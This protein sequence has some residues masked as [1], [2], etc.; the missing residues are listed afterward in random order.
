MT[1]FKMEQSPNGQ[2]YVKL[3]CQQRDVVEHR[4]HGR[5]QPTSRPQF[6]L[7]QELFRNS[8]HNCETFQAEVRR[9]SL[10]RAT[11]TWIHHGRDPRLL[12]KMDGSKVDG[13]FKNVGD[14]HVTC[15]PGR[16]EVPGGTFP[17]VNCCELILLGRTAHQ[18]EDFHGTQRG[19]RFGPGSTWS[20]WT[21]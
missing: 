21:H 20:P 10:F 7:R 6:K 12:K 8:S 9:F 16:A 3:L 5:N 18:H 15:K 17:T 11:V 14:L 4:N 19:R 13:S 2:M 1:G